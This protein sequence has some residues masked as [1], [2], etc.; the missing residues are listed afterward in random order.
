MDQMHRAH[1]FDVE[2]PGPSL[3]RRFAV[4]FLRDETG[5][6]VTEE[7]LSLS[8]LAERIRTTTAQT[9]E[10][11]PWLKL[12]RFGSVRTVAGSL[13]HNANVIAITGVEADY[14]GEAISYDQA[15]ETLLKA[16]LLALLYTSPSHT[17]DTPR[18]RVLCPTSKELP[19][20][21]RDSRLGR[22]NGLF[23]GVFS[24][25]SWT[26]SQSYYF[27]AVGQNPSHK[28]QLFDG[29]P[30]DQLD[31][32]D[33][34]WLGKPGTVGSAAAQTPGER[35]ITGRLDIAAA[36]ADI[37]SGE[38]Y[39]QATVRLAGLWAREGMAMAV[40][41]QVLLAGME[42][43]PT[44][45]RDMRWQQRRDDVDRCVDDIYRKHATS[46]GGAADW[47]EKCQTN[48]RKEPRPNLA[49]ALLALREAPQVKDLLG[50]DE[51]LRAPLLLAPVPRGE[52]G[53]PFPRSVRDTDVSAIQ[54][55]IQLA[56][57]AGLSKETTHQAVE[58]RAQETAFHPVRDYL[59]NITWDGTPR[60]R[61]WLHRYLGVP[62][63]EYAAT[64]GMMFL[65]SMVA[66]VC[67]PG[68][69]ADYMLVLEGPQGAGKSTVCRILGGS[70]FSD[71]LP[72][73]RA[74]KD[75]SQ[76]L[77]GKWLIEVAELSALDR[78]EAAA[79]K[80]FITRPEERYR[81][82]YG[83]REVVEPR[84]CVFVGTTNR[85]AYLRDETGARRFWP[86]R[87][88]TVDVAALKADRDQLFAEA[89]ALYS[90]GRAW[91]PDAEFERKHVAR[92]QEQ[93]F[94]VD[95]W[96]EAI[97][98][99]LVSETTVTVMSVARNVLGMEVQRVGTSDSRRITAILER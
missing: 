4:S 33:L 94:E 5:K 80:A 72:D 58:Q 71:G 22:L 39:H 31:E 99:H 11:L 16:N 84:Q 63:T 77:N 85:E 2:A 88:G 64:I 81:P 93:R 9:K 43:V 27:G 7:S 50:F 54:E 74:G 67:Q 1:A 59:S 44:E 96:E 49:N 66:R 83:R 57:I 75:V 98:V 21:R 92:E 91:W 20:D 68:C 95:P 87:V 29:Q 26:L 25:E 82:S 42:A 28:V 55:W 52:A 45:R 51:M 37:T 15:A 8:E 35:I 24:G 60:L 46:Q 12:A 47:L 89:A 62:P 10:D 70:W 48:S 19:G 78:A 73:I 76:H 17:E 65:V 23:Q 69:K 34:T 36:I 79:L 13:R 53:G 6:S 97:A 56:G 86:V 61:G 32:L 90:A 40:A 38:N 3:L 18:W 30:I 14:D 41:K